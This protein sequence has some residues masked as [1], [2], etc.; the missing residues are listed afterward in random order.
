MP[1]QLR[2]K[3]LSYTPKTTWL[4]MASPWH[5][6]SWPKLFGSWPSIQLLS[7][8]TIWHLVQRHGE[9]G[10]VA[11]PPHLGR[12]RG[13]SRDQDFY[14]RTQRLWYRFHSASRTA[15]ETPGRRNP[16]FSS[17]PVRRRLCEGNL[18]AR[19]PLRDHI[20]TPQRWLFFGSLLWNVHHTCLKQFWLYSLLS[21]FVMWTLFICVA[22]T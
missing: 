12:E 13:M 6:A 16:R 7:S 5:S 2:P 8:S 4:T 11:D 1:F 15:R 19:R 14:I 18:L 10:S 22:T 9:T 3:L 21:P 20:V 17:P